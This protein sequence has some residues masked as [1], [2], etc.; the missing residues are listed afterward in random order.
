M[1]S[2]YTLN[3]KAILDTSDIKAKLSSIKSEVN[4]NSSGNS[5]VTRSLENA[6][7]KLTNQITQLQNVL[8]RNQQTIQQQVAV[9]RTNTVGHPAVVPSYW[10]SEK[11]ANA[12]RFGQT[13]AMV[14]M[15]ATNNSDSAFARIF[16]ST[17][18][19]AASGSP[20][21]P[22]GMGIMGAVGLMQGVVS[23]IQANEEEFSKSLD[24]LTQRINAALSQIGVAQ[25]Q[26]EF[27]QRTREYKTYSTDELENEL[28]IQ[29]AALE[30][31][32]NKQL[33]S[34]E[35]GQ[36]QAVIAERN[37][38][39]AEARRVYESGDAEELWNS[40]ITEIMDLIKVNHY[41]QFYGDDFD[42][43]VTESNFKAY[44]EETE[45]LV[46]ELN[47]A[48]AG[49]IK[50]TAETKAYIQA[51]EAELIKRKQLSD[52]ETKALEDK[53]RRTEELRKKQ[54]A[55]GAELEGIYNDYYRDEMQ[56]V[57]MERQAEERAIAAN[58]ERN[59]QLSIIEKNEN[60]LSRLQNILGGIGLTT[61]F[62]SLSKMGF[63]MGEV[64]TDVLKVQEDQLNVQREIRRLVEEIKNARNNLNTSIAVAG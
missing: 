23:E 53:I 11:V 58:E 54:A 56:R 40:D 3:L 33:T 47:D 4:G 60:E 43:D 35:F 52:A 51:I 24:A 9:S 45:R 27:E 29:K 13:A 15:A 30:R 49:S 46:Q 16:S 48:T 50:R 1:A 64:E 34:G 21:G 14:G 42:N 32:Q 6:I 38:I 26:I 37:A 18:L 44:I 62:T 41:G 5:T 36:K 63:N 10:N 22:W 7:T 61:N 25:K 31:Q 20:L 59:K 17:A 12:M 2:N 8:N 55:E 19:G 39:L 57:L 28:E